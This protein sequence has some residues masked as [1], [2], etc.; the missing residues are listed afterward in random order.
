MIH[1]LPIVFEMR[2]RGYPDTD[3]Y[4]VCEVVK[5]WDAS[6]FGAVAVANYLDEHYPDWTDE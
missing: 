1:E 5:D 3:T 4:E 2:R 6:F